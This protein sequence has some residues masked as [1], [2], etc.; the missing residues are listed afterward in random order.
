MTRLSEQIDANGILKTMQ[1]IGAHISTEQAQDMIKRVDADGDGKIS[2]KEFMT[3]MQPII[4]DQY[5]NSD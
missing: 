1:G 2:E 3:I 5:I 4:M